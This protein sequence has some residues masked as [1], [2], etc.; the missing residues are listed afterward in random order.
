MGEL[1]VRLSA[2]LHTVLG[3]E[4]T[5]VALFAE[6]EGFAH[7]HYHV[8]PRM[9]W[10]EQA[11]VGPRVFSFLGKS[12]AERVPQDQQD[13]LAHQIAAAFGAQAAG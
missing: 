6:T 10:F 7:L 8:V 12:E 13:M 3:C 9:A 5:Y 4:K 2:A 1:L 11:Q